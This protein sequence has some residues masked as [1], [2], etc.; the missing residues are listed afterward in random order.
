MHFQPVLDTRPALPA[1]H[2]LEALIR[3]PRGTIAEAPSIL[4]EYARKKHA[5]PRALPPSRLTGIVNCCTI[6]T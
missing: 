6:Q 4:F 2:Y 1:P 5:A 3:G